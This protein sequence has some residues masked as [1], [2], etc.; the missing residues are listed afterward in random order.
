MRGVYL[1]RGINAAASLKRMSD[2]PDIEDRDSLLFRGINAAASLKRVIAYFR[3]GYDLGLFRG[4]NAAASLK[5]VSRSA[6]P[7]A[8]TSL[9]RHQ[10][11]GLIEAM[12]ESETPIRVG[13]SSAASTPRPH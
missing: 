6:M 11:R 7:L 8:D 13:D 1:F 12:A 9:P 10:R 5:P 4:I 3:L 2:H